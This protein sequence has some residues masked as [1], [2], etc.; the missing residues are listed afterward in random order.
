M[1]GPGFPGTLFQSLGPHFFT[2]F[3]FSLFQAQG[4]LCLPKW[5]Y[6]VWGKWYKIKSLASTWP[7]AT[8]Y[9]WEGG[10]QCRRWPPWW[11]HQMRPVGP[12]WM[13]LQNSCGGGVNKLYCTTSFI[14]GIYWP[15]KESLFWVFWLYSREECQISLHVYNF[16][17]C[18]FGSLLL[19]LEVP[20]SFRISVSR[21]PFHSK[22]HEH[23]PNNLRWRTL[24]E[25]EGGGAWTK[26][27]WITE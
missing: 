13:N 18:C 2:R 21:S 8:E 17:N 1:A 7:V 26:I 27:Y 12:P 22:L 10:R 3:P 16:K 20:K 11:W 23:E 5:I 15:L 24:T 6:L 19:S 14:F 9:W 4:R 25:L